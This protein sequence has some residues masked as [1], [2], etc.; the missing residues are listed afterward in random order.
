[1]LPEAPLDIF[2]ELVPLIGLVP[3]TDFEVNGGIG[4]RYFF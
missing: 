4:I 3:A 2:F 1:M